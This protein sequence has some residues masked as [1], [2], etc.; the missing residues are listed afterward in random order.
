M[1]EISHQFCPHFLKKSKKMKFPHI[2]RKNMVEYVYYKGN[3][4]K[5][6]SIDSTLYHF[7]HEYTSDEVL[8]GG[9]YA[10]KK[11]LNAD[12][13]ANDIDIYVGNRGNF[14]RFSFNEISKR[15]IKKTNAKFVK[16]NK[17][18][19]IKIDE[20]D[21]W[22]KE[23]FHKS[24]IRS[25]NFLMNT[26][27]EKNTK[28]QLIEMECWAGRNLLSNVD[29]LTDLPSC[30]TYSVTERGSKIFHIPEKLVKRLEIRVKPI[31]EE[32]VCGERR[33]KYTYATLS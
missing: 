25:H 16:E 14:S 10:L 33:E 19:E 6:K 27:E 12:W 17:F 28:I 29:F 8:V 13:E 31:P 23:N 15:F 30:V 3:F 24:I 20:D 18:D 22:R 2:I 26:L 5:G 9:S 4:P 7:M 32:L 11:F 1:L 21:E